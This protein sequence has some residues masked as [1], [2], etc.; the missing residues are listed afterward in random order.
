M[1]AAT[2]QP[3]A[4]VGPEAARRTGS[5]V[6]SELLR[7]ATR[8][9]IQV[10]LGLA[11]LGWLGAIGIGLL[12]FD[13]PTP[14]DYAVAEAEY[15][16]V[17]AD[18]EEWREE[19][20][21]QAEAAGQPTDAF[22]GPP[23]TVENFLQVEPFDLGATAE[24]GAMGFAAAAAVLAFLVGATWIGAE[25][26]NRSIVALLFW[27]PNRLKVMGAKLG[28]LTVAAAVIGVAAQAAWLAMAGILDAAAGSGAELPDGFWSE[29]LAAQGRA[30]L[31]T[32]LIALIGFGLANLTRNTGAALGVGFVYFAVLENA[33]RIW[34]PMVERWLLTRN[35]VSLVL[36]GGSEVYDYDDID[37]TGNPAT[38]LIS[39]LHGGLV[40]AAFAA[41][42]VGIGAWLF[43]RRDL[44]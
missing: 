18:E 39:N 20:A 15:E 4:P 11:V 10:L 12:S 3:K 26:S 28:V 7:F 30:V 24:V 35:A 13:Q 21:E 38:Y 19:C 9:F 8:R 23:L 14:A 29:L 16:R 31:L 44:H 27:V 36:P 25:W 34:D 32:V 1:S 6:R 17:I 37:A 5:L 22:C 43:A 40:V 41:V 33:L 2:Q 42:I